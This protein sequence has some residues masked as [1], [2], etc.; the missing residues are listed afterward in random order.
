MRGNLRAFCFAF[1]VGALLVLIPI[2]YGQGVT[3]TL[4]GSVKDSTGAVI[5]GASVTLLSESQGIVSTPVIT[6]E[7]GDYVFPNLAA[8]TYT[9]QV[10]MPGFKIAKRS[11]V[12]VSPG[13]NI[14]LEA[15]TLEV[16]G[17][18]E[19]IEVSAESSPVLLQ[20]TTGE[21]SYSITPEQTAAL[22]VGNRSYV[23]LLNLVPGVALDE[24]S[25]TSNLDTGTGGATRPT[26]RIGGGGFDNYMVDGLTTMSS[27]IN[28]P[29]ARISS[30][31]ISEVKVATFGYGAEYG[32]SS[33]NQINAVTKSGTNQFHGSFYDL[34]R[35]SRFGYA[36]SMTNV[37]NG[38]PKAAGDQR[39]LGWTIGGPIGK[40]GGNNKLFFFWNQEYNPRITANS[41][42]RY[43][44]PTVLERQGDFSQ[45]TDNL[46]NPYPYIKDPLLSGTCN[47]TNQAAC[48]KDNGV[49][50][51]I[52]ANR[53]WSTGVNILKWWPAPNCPSACSSYLPNAAY[54]YETT[55]PSVHLLGW[56]PVIRIDYA[57]TQKLRINFKTTEYLQPNKV[58]PGR[59]PGFSDSTQDN[60]AVYTWSSVVN[61]TLNSTTFMEGSWGWQ[62][63]HQEGCS[64]TGGDP[65][66]CI[67][68]DAVNPSANRNTA[69]FG[70]IP[71]LFP[72]ATLLDKST[73]AYKIMQNLGSKTTVWDGSR[74]Q[75]APS[76]SWGSRITNQPLNWS[77]P[78]SSF[79]LEDRNRTGNFSL[80]K[81]KGSHTIK[82]GYQYA[83]L[84]QTR[85]TGAITGS[86]NFGNDTANP[87]DTTFGYANAL[88]G[89][90][91]SYSQV[92]RWG[93]GAHTGINH[94][95]FLQ[96]NW[97]VNQSLTLDYGMRF[98][99]EVPT[100]D[101]YVSFSN[102]FPEKFTRAGAPRLYTYGCDTGVYPCTGSARRAMDPVTGAFV[103]TSAQASLIVGT[104]VPGT[105]I[106][107]NGAPTNGLIPAGTNGLPKTGYVYPDVGL[108]PRFGVAYTVND[109]FV[110]RGAAG[111]FIDRP[112]GGSTY[113]VVNNPPFSSNITVRYGLLQDISTS[114]LSTQSP[115]TLSVFTYDN[116]LPK[117]V[118]WN[119][120]VQTKLPFS[121]T[122]DLTYTGQHS[123][124]EQQSLNINTIDYGAAYLASLQDR[125]Q[126]ASGVT[127]SIVNTN[128]NSI[129]SFLG[130]GSISQNQP[131]GW[132]T[133]HSIQLAFNRR[134]QSG[135][136]FGF[137]DTISLYDVSSVALRLQH[138]PDGS[139]AIRSD[140]AQAQELL[141]A[142]HP[143]THVMRAN[144]IWQLPKLNTSGG[145]KTLG[146]LLNDWSLASIWS[147]S[148]GAAYNV[149]YS[150]TSNGANIDITGSPDFGGRAVVVGDPGTGCSGD[151]LK[152]YNAAA[153][154]GPAAGSVG[155]ESG[156]GYLKYC[157]QSKMDLSISR[158]I[159]VGEKGRAVQLRLDTYNA[160]NQAA[161]TG[162]NNQ[163]QFA[164]PAANTVITNLPFDSSGNVVS[165]FSKPRGAGFGVANAF[166][167]PRTMQVQVRLQF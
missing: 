157:F 105:G 120:G 133:Y 122:L 1:A 32:R 67:T 134:L 77:L 16:G 89:V 37:L 121:S 141:G 151:P 65:N 25:L 26:S 161:V 81:V 115:P 98:V 136:S 123:Y 150:Y 145:M 49:L 72:D 76:F 17:T 73:L 146:Y 167:N 86:I 92:S 155:L 4:S 148:S 156:N 160:F 104:L 125:S 124:N 87:L 27:G 3:G 63:H 142:N 117:S 69:G 44:M 162:R 116:K 74:V 152:G 55:Y 130:Y 93:E 66:W 129:R 106:T 163:M 51:K 153:F 83:H 131:T 97:K 7:R 75:A 101:A 159:R 57:P 61:Y 14:R 108:A 56:E 24:S 8:N 21:K 52:P 50:G 53:I 23:S 31:S 127:T 62:A 47:A 41:V 59:I 164:S 107:T 109:R 154:K 58:I 140:Q 9:V 82:G 85:G 135:I 15:L 35:H 103:G 20:T 147:G 126:T 149:T 11:G 111:L 139:L 54:N 70:G 45:S 91:S 46:G 22:P 60:F 71:Y 95:F 99:H 36:N 132:H 34:E 158:S 112:S 119:G 64:I 118:Q 33:G 114:G 6:N 43:R 137:N 39:D 113:S 143:Q 90:F 96:D 110:V 28:R 19:V 5:P 79:I 100:Y 38:D 30:E 84:V 88:L 18:S 68:G 165:S 42:T 12:A 48:F 40:P 29:T 138:N 94:E 80:T 144:A 13:S 128:P 10:E 102:F 78:W 166:Q 2:A